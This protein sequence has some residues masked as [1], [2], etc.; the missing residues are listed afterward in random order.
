MRHSLQDTSPQAGHRPPAT[1]TGR[2]PSLPHLPLPSPCRTSRQ[3]VALGRG[4]ATPAGQPETGAA[5]PPTVTTLQR[6]QVQVKAPP[7]PP[8]LN[9]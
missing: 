8:A 2:K 6:L 9:T 3:L 7:T 5:G 4:A 1:D